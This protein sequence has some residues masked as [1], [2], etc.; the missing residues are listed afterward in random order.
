M[1]LIWSVHHEGNE[2][3]N[4]RARHSTRT[5]ERQ[6]MQKNEL[7]NRMSAA[8][9]AA[10]QELQLWWVGMRSGEWGGAKKSQ[11]HQP[12]L[13]FNQS[14]NALWASVTTNMEVNWVVL[15]LMLVFLN[16]HLHKQ[17]SSHLITFNMYPWGVNYKFPYRRTYICIVTAS[18]NSPIHLISL[19]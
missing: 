12:A 10:R 14:F 6:R 19:T 11:R 5:G 3:M 16:I 7:G 18:A 1:V 15:F 2:E 4:I 13:S 8:T 17:S 9:A